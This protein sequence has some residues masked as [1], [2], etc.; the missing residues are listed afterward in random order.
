V[1]VYDKNIVFVKVNI[2][3][4]AMTPN[5]TTCFKEAI[6]FSGKIGL[7]PCFPVS[8]KP[9]FELSEICQFE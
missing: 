9:Q 1:A 8:Y 2:K 5:F 4:R 6:E 7:F 3:F